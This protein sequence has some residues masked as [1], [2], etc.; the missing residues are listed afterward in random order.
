MSAKVLSASGVLYTDR[1]KFY[2]DPQQFSSLYPSVTPFLSLLMAK[3]MRDAG[4]DPDFKMFEHRAGWRY[5]YLDIN[6][7]NTAW[8]GSGTPGATITATVDGATGITVDSSLLATRVE[9]WDST[10]TT[11]KGVARVHAVNS[12]TEIVLKAIGNAESATE[13]MSA[14][15]D[16]DR[17][18][19]ID[20][21][22]GEGTEAPEASSDE[23][24]VVWGSC[25]E[26]KTA[27]EITQVLAD[28]A[29]RGATDELRRL[30]E[31]KGNEH[32]I[33]MSRGLLLGYRPGGIGGTAHGAGG[34][35]DSTFLNHITDADSKTVRSSMGV[36][37]ALRRYGRTSGSQ[38]NYF[39]FAKAN[40]TYNDWVDI[41]EKV[42]QYNSNGG[43]KVGAAGPG[44]VGFLAK[45]G[46]E[47]L[48]TKDSKTRIS[49]PMSDTKQSSIGFRYREVETPFGVIRLVLEETFRG[50]PY[51]DD[52][53]I[54]D[55]G[56]VELVRYGKGG[57][58]EYSTNIKT[59]NN[60]RLVKDEYYH[61]MGVKLGLMEAHS[62][63]R[64]T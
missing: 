14:L 10:L 26:H 34:G 48:L 17:L 4:S 7:G 6:S 23:L 8:S 33:K 1:R 42:F 54:V 51:N 18:Y 56:N 53:L 19:V 39:T 11:Y 61:N 63:I 12:A 64:L 60:P 37:P 38:Q 32:K 27:V 58:G 30:R 49:I 44:A 20:T 3:S 29:L 45:I 13:A 59:D 46:A 25:Q 28:A 55:D 22:H 9:I 47:G 41:T 24:E 15:A 62:F 35:T 36:I 21:A 50:G 52:I 43:V 40:M 16:N 5:Q 2:I 31:D 57:G